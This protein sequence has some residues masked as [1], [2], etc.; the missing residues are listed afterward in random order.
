MNSS[1]PVNLLFRF[2]SSI[3][4]GSVNLNLTCRTIIVSYEGLDS[5]SPSTLH[6]LQFNLG[7]EKYHI[8]IY[9]QYNTKH[10]KCSHHLVTMSETNTINAAHVTFRKDPHSCRPGLRPR[11]HNFTLSAN[12]DSNHIPC[13]LYRSLTN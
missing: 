8:H 5:H 10:E 6:A 13:V 11:P 7:R 4:P 12:D 9:I 3:F 2:H 1:Y